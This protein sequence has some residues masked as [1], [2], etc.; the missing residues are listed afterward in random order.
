[1]KSKQINPE[2]KEAVKK[3]KAQVQNNMRKMKYKSK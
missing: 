2:L 1:M 3:Q